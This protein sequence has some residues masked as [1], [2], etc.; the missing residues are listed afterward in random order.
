[1]NCLLQIP[2]LASFRGNE[3]GCPQGIGQSEI[4][5]FCLPRRTVPISFARWHRQD[6]LSA[7]ANDRRPEEACSDYLHRSRSEVLGKFGDLVSKTDLVKEAESWNLQPRDAETLV[8][9][10]YFES[11]SGFA[12][13][14][15]AKRS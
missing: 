4:D 8:F 5:G 7:G 15:V 1:M 3:Y 10:V 14:S 9:V 11:E 2:E 12:E 6:W 13:I